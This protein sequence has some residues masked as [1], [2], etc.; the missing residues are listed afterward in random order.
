M[1]N[2]ILQQTPAAANGT[3]QLTL[4]DYR[5][6]SRVRLL[7]AMFTPAG[8]LFAGE[9]GIVDRVHRGLYILFPDFSEDEIIKLDKWMVEKVTR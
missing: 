3:I 8:F 2:P 6:G 7:Q 9:I 4:S 1:T 5:S